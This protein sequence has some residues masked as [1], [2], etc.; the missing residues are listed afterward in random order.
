ML[1]SEAEKGGS[2]GGQKLT[3]REQC[4]G[5]RCSVC[6]LA[7]SGVQRSTKERGYESLGLVESGQE[8]P[9]FKVTNCKHKHK[10]FH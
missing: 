2:T 9:G 7:Q 1:A 8:G 3:W 10:G 4:Q 5:I 6:L